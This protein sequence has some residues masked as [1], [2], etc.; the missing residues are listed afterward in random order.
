VSPI[1]CS[2]ESEQIE[3]ENYA[4]CTEKLTIR[5]NKSFNIRKKSKTFDTQKI[6][7]QIETKDSSGYFIS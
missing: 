3:D 7:I 1:K 5:E 4:I 2:Q 6:V